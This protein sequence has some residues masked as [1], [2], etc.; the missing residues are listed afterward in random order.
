MPQIF[1]KTN[2]AQPTPVADGTFQAARF[3]RYGGLFVTP[4]TQGVYGL[5]DEGVYF[6]SMQIAAGPVPPT[7]YA[8]TAAAATAFSNTAV[9]ATIRNTD[10]AGGKRL[11]L[12]F[13]RIQIAAAGTAGTRLEYAVTVDNITRYTSGGA[14]NT[15]YNT[16]MDATTAAVGVM[17]TGAITAAAASGSA[18]IVARGSLDVANPAAGQAY[19][20]NCGAGDQPGPTGRAAVAAPVV[21]GPGSHTA[22]LHLWLP[23]QSAA[24]TGEITAGWWER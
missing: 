24:P 13:I 12:D 10:S 15:Q 1:G 9:S 6:N 3:D 18:R 2:R 8:L 23:S 22:V 4:I 21:L 11:Y 17:H 19:L 14:A 7:A 5:G 20:I 16:N